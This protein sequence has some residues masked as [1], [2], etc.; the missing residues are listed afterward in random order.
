[1][2]YGKRL[3]RA[4]TLAGKERKELA[5]AIGVK[6]QSIGQVINGQT[7]ALTAE[8]S[9]RAAKF[10]KVDHHWLATGE[11]LAHPPV[12]AGTNLSQHA[13]ALAKHF[14]RLPVDDQGVWAETFHEVNQLVSR[15]IEKIQPT[16]QQESGQETQPESLPS[17]TQTGKI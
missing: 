6:V 10:L 8:N 13:L 9:A 2:S 1:M 7:Q 15:A 17:K 16:E 14:D 12:G 3:D 5:N 11:G 4:L